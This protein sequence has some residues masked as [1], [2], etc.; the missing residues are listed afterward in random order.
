MLGSR[1]ECQHPPCVQAMRLVRPVAPLW[2][3]AP[4]HHHHSR[5]EPHAVVRGFGPMLSWDADTALD[6]VMPRAQGVT[7]L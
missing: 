1:G 7:K 6:S 2:T 3:I 4:L 5:L